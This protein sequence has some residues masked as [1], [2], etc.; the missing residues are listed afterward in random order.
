MQLIKKNHS[1]SFTILAGFSVIFSQARWSDFQQNILFCYDQSARSWFS[2]VLIRKKVNMSWNI[3]R[4]FHVMKCVS[5]GGGLSFWNFL[6]SFCSF[7]MF[8]FYNFFCKGF[9][10][11]KRVETYFTPIHPKKSNYRMILE[12]TGWFFILENVRV[13][14][15]TKTNRLRSK[16]FIL[17]HQ[18][19]RM[20]FIIYYEIRIN[21]DLNI[22]G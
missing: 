2:L 7:M 18:I 6:F 19:K 14:Q 22:K 20:W 1:S 5:E 11:L 9:K 21:V 10:G 15:V 13:E 12:I 16:D 4:K 3:A 17:H 8:L